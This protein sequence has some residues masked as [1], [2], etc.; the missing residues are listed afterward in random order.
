MSLMVSH[1]TPVDDMH[2]TWPGSKAVP[3]RRELPGRDSWQQHAWAV[4]E[5]LAHARR[6]REQRQ[7]M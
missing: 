1:P 5:I 7:A 2:T 4:T 3:G 6:G